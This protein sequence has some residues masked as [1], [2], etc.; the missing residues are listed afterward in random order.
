MQA[1]TA[2]QNKREGSETLVMHQ[3]LPKQARLTPRKDVCTCGKYNS[4]LAII[5]KVSIHCIFT[6]NGGLP[7]IGIA[8]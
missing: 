8:P 5:V 3:S 6:G 7:T 4:R 1:E 2:K